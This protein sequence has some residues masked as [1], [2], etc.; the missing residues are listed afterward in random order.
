MLVVNTLPMA[1]PSDLFSE[2]LLYRFRLRPLNGPASGG[3][4]WRFVPTDDEYVL[5]CVFSSPDPT[6]GR[7]RTGRH[8]HLLDRREG[9]VPRERP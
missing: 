9:L 6:A 8:L 1:K 4:G 3:Q 2:G 7:A 5:D